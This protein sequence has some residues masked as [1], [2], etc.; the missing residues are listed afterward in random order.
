MRAS[1]SAGTAEPRWS[2]PTVDTG[3]GVTRAVHVSVVTEVS[4]NVFRAEW[5]SEDSHL[6]EPR[7]RGHWISTITVAFQEKAVRLE[8]R[9]MNP[10]GL[11]VVGYSVDHV[12]DRSA[13]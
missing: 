8:D 12:D 10:I 13:K 2:A 7:G 3:E 9:Y 1:R 6:T 11:Q 5:S 4:P